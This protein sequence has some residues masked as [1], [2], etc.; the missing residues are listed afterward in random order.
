MSH[1]KNVLIVTPHKVG[2]TETFIRAHIEQLDARVYY[3][4]GWELD[5]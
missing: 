3:L 2:L 5:F 1:K 4:Y